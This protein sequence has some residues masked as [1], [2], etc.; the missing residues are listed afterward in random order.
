V[1]KILTGPR[2]TA[3]TGVQ[4][5]LVSRRKF[6]GYFGWSVSSIQEAGKN[7]DRLSNET[8]ASVWRG[9]KKGG[10]FRKEKIFGITE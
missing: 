7:W 8:P 2:L 3:S 9:K 4:G 1:V 10:M 6:Q 5:K